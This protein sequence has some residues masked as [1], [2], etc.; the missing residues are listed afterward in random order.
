MRFV[1]R[2]NHPT[3]IYSVMG[4]RKVVST[5]M[6]SVKRDISPRNIVAMIG[7]LLAVGYAALMIWLI[8]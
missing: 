3:V 1:T 7:A 6:E 8:F 4:K 2:A 5:V